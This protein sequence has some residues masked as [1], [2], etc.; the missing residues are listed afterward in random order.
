MKHFLLSTKNIKLSSV[1]WNSFAATMNSFQTMLLI[2]VLTRFGTDMD[3][4]V[5]AIAYAVGNL[6][7]MVGKY[8]VRQFQVTDTNEKYSFRDY[9]GARVVSIG[10]MMLGSICY[11][12]VNMVRN[13]YT[14]WKAAIVFLICMV[15]LVEAA[16]DVYHGRMQQ[17]GRLDVAGKILGIRLFSFIVCYAIIFVLTRKLLPTTILSLIITLVMSLFMNFSVRDTFDL[18]GKADTVHIKKILWECLPLCISTCLNTYVTNAPKYIVDTIVTDDVQTAFIVVYMPVFVLALLANYIFQPLLK[19]LGDMWNQNRQGDVKKRVL[20]LS[21]FIIIMT[22]AAA[23]AG[24][25]I[26]IPVLQ[27][28]YGIDLQA[29]RFILVLLIACG[30]MIA[31]H[32]L[33]IMVFTIA[34]HQKY[35]MFGYGAA[36]LAEVTLGRL[37][38]INSGLM[39]LCW[40]FAAVMGGLLLYFIVL[41]LVLGR[42]VDK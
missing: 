40:F 23:G 28:L 36:A 12:A 5:F 1:C 20:L 2:M 24:Y 29:Y 6:M 35:I 31:A 38:L 26:G 30:G 14:P 15:K 25:L 9:A 13:S 37:V 18:S 21:A 27:L 34:R 39:G 41:T 42:H 7:L 19:D 11:V 16:E 4:S 32:N 33:F 3:S 22:L 17:R 8:G 10:I